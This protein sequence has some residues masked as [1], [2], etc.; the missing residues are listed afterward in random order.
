MSADVLAM[1]IFAVGALVQLTAAGVALLLIPLS[2]RQRAWVLLTCGLVL[3]VWRRL[4]VVLMGTSASQ[5]HESITALLVSAFML[6]GIV[7]IRSIFH[8]MK[9]TAEH[10]RIER[11]RT[12][13]YLDLTEAIVVGLDTGGRIALINR[14]GA[15]ILGAEKDAL[16]G[17]DWHGRFLPP[18][19]RHGERELFSKFMRGVAEPVA[20]FESTVMT[21]AG[22]RR[23]V[24]WHNAVQREEDG[25]ITGTLSF[26]I[27]ITEHKEA[28][29]AIERMACHDALTGLPNRT[30]FESRAKMMIAGARHSGRPLALLF[31]DVDD[32]RGVNDRYGHMVAD[33]LLREF[34]NRI[35]DVF[36]KEDTIARLA[37]DEFGVLLPVSGTATADT[38]VRKAL[39]ALKHPY[40]IYGKEIWST[41]SAGVALYPRDAEDIDGLLRRADAAARKTQRSGGNGLSFYVSG[42]RDDMMEKLS[43]RHDL[44]AAVEHEQFVLY[45]QPQMRVDTGE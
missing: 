24:V 44:A 42:M 11:G 19:R 9:E 2:G 30:L 25:R 22:D 37:G 27:D 13:E 8:S 14:A 36:R 26:G 38:A 10:L 33:Q 35:T 43:L 21:I 17:E 31:F 29:A 20:C 16:L 28:E 34:A 32:L 7:G 41:A 45:Y 5:L 12:Q 39:E 18:E 15:R 3:Q 23:S 40:R 6:L 4:Y 1:V